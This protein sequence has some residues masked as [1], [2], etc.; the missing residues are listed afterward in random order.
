MGD[1]DYLFVYDSLGWLLRI[2]AAQ[3]R[4]LGSCAVSAVVSK[5]S[6]CL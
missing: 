5:R 4:G 6:G 3:D 1:F 2:L